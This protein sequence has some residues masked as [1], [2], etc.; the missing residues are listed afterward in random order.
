MTRFDR[1]RQSDP[2]GK[3]Y[4][5]KVVL[6]LAPDVVGGPLDV[7]DVVGVLLI[8]VGPALV[9]VDVVAGVGAPLSVK[10]SFAAL[11]CFC[12]FCFLLTSVSLL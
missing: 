8:V 4:V 2:V 12:G 9:V 1:R 6:K 11:L 10:I 7:P 3:I 5:T